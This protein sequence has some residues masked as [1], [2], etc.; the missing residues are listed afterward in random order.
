M[1]KIQDLKLNGKLRNNRF[2]NFKLKLALIY[3]YL[4]TNIYAI[5]L[6]IMKNKPS[7]SFFGYGCY[8]IYFL[9]S[10][11]VDLIDVGVV[12]WW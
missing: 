4:K 1:P 7:N 11:G 3:L 10:V 6:L 12:K 9:H 2:L 5:Y 8:S